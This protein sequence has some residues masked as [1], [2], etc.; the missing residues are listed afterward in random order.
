V[1]SPI[2]HSCAIQNYIAILELQQPF[3]NVNN[4]RI[5]VTSRYVR[6]N[7]GAAKS[8]KYY[9]FWVCICS[10]RYPACKAHAPYYIVICGVSGSAD[11]FHIIP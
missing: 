3:N 4:V 9:I 10:L 2:R 8:N 1:K 7:T 11:F 6:A 5:N